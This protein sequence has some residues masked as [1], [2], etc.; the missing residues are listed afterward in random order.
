M[1]QRTIVFILL[2]ITLL[3]SCQPVIEWLPSSNYELVKK[4]KYILLVK[5]KKEIKNSA[6]RI[7]FNKISFEVVKS[8]KGNLKDK[9]IFLYGS[10]DYRGSSVE[11]N[12][13]KAR[14]GAYIGMCRAYDY[15]LGGYFLVFLNR[16]KLI[17]SHMFARVNEEVFS[18]NDPWVESVKF[19]IKTAKLNNYKEE[20]Q[21]LQNMLNSKTNIAGLKED[22]IHHFKMPNANKSEEDLKKMF[23]TDSLKESVLWAFL[24]KKGK[25]VSGATVFKNLM[26]SDEWLKHKAPVLEYLVKIKATNRIDFLLEAKKKIPSDYYHQDGERRILSVVGL[27][28]TQKD[29]NLIYEMLKKDKHL[30]YA[31]SPYLI[32]YPSQ[33]FID[34]IY[35]LNINQDEYSKST[36][37]L[38]LAKMGDKK[39]LQWAKKNRLKDF[40]DR[41]IAYYIIA[42]SPLMEADILAQEV[43][44]G[45]YF[46]KKD[47]ES[48]VQG[49]KES[50][51]KYRDIR[52]DEIQEKYKKDSSIYNWV[53]F[54]KKMILRNSK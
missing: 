11:G 49:Y 2:N 51:S 32:K 22:I 39:I 36:I 50:T 42:Q 29:K 14:P 48:L 43:I 23:Q 12:F 33:K 1:I 7:G 53:K 6:N 44:S 17:L 41:W 46:E 9:E 28:A 15:K 24:N 10:S 13:T 18:E 4:A 40:P 21:R 45:K 35:T 8:L 16:K 37:K 52:L 5:A 47:I 34:I 54:T 31:F 3:Y 27:L 30:I 25:V 38:L 20:K 19:Y 26:K